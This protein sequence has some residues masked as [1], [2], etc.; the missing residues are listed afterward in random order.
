[1][2]KRDNPDRDRKPWKLLLWTVVTGLVFGLIHLG[3]LPEDYLR[4]ARNSFH[5]H[6]ASGNIVVIAIDEQSLRRVGNWPWGRRYDAQ[7]VDRLMDAGAKRVFF[8]IN[9]S[10]PSDPADDRAL[11]TRSSARVKFRSSCDPGA[12]PG[13]RPRRCSTGRCRRSAS[14]PS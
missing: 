14:M 6:R 8:D 10:Y 9:F 7:M 3:Q 11:P 13:A 5:D 1:V 4:I 12:A 2:S